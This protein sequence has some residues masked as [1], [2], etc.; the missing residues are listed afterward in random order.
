MAFAFSIILYLHSYRLTLRLAFPKPGGIQ[1]YHV[2]LE[3][4]DGLGPFSPPVALCAHDKEEPTPCSRH[5]PFWGKPV[6]VFGLLA[7]TTF[8]E[9]SHALAIP[10][11][12]A[13]S[14][15]RSQR[16]LPLAASVPAL[17]LWVPFRFGYC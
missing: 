15:V 8:I 7:M 1:A 6:S 13:L 16:H 5:V 14:V 2:P 9:S 4:P 11:I 3:R 10:S 17:R 12:L